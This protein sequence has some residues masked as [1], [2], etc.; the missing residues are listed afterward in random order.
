MRFEQLDGLLRRAG[1]EADAAEVHGSL[2]G[3]LCSVGETCLPDWLQE[4]LRGTDATEAVCGELE[5]TL[6]ELHQREGKRLEQ[7]DPGFEPLLPEDA[8]E[9][10]RRASALGDW[11]QGF[12]QGLAHG[13]IPEPEVLAR[14][15]QAPHAAEVVSDFARIAGAASSPE[16]DGADAEQSEHD[17]M[18]LV[19]YARVG[20]QL[21]FEE[22][23]DWRE[24]GIS[25]RHE[26]RQP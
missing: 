19:E 13:R 24:R 16:M 12:L 11:C 21:T 6:R 26:P 25:G 22:L 4:S 23:A 10:A 8:R 14:R 15:E 7:R 5:R 20:A 9:L 1:A 3:R 18:Q 2:C 17:L